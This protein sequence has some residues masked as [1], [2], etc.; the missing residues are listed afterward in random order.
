MKIQSVNLRNGLR[1][2]VAP[3]RTH[4]VVSCMIWYRVGSRNEGR[5]ETGLSHFLE[6]MM[7]KGTRR[8]RKGEIDRVTAQLGGSNNAFTNTDHTAYYFNFSSDRWLTALDIEADRMRGCLLDG[9]EFEAEKQVVIEELRMGKDDP[10][11]DLYQEVQSA[12]YQVHPYHHPVIGWEEEIGK[13]SRERMQRYYDRHYA[14]ARA[15]LVLVGDLD[16]ASAIR[17]VRKRFEKIRHAPSADET[18]ILAEPSQKSERRVVL[19]RATQLPRLAI[20]YPTCRVGE[21]EDYA[22]DLISAI[23]SYGKCSR[24]YRRLVKTGLATHATTEND[25]RLDPGLFWA[26]AEVAHGKSKEK[27][28]RILTEELESRLV[29]SPVTAFE[30]QKAKRVLRS[31][32]LFQQESI[33][34]LAERIGRWEMHG[35]Y[36]E[37]GSYLARI[38]RVTARQVQQVARKYFRSDARCV[39]WSMPRGRS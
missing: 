2:I 24:L 17:E 22:L 4:P 21:P 16:A 18:P 6:H 13:L 25:T 10:W 5:G 33:A 20:A 1:V 14:P 11:R 38:E 29:S 26:G 15:V 12:A 36:R 37:L 35:G 3:R 9:K 34:E 27:A 19:Y 39:G 28:E 8:L 23:L 7:F 31:S 32:F 30:L